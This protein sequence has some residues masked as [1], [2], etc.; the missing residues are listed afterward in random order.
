MPIGPESVNRRA[1][2]GK[3]K[4]RGIDRGIGLGKK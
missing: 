3:E 4:E 2:E 1:Y